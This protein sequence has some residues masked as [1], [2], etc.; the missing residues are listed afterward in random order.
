MS[1]GRMHADEPDIDTALV[2]RLI[3]GQF[4]GWKEL[5]VERVSSSGT[6][7]VMYRLGE[8]MVVRLPRRSAAVQDIH[9]EHVWLPRLAPRLPVPVPVPLAKG[10]PADGYPWPWSVYRWLEGHNPGREPLR[11]PAPLGEDLAGF[12]TA[13]RRIDPG[14][15]P[16]SYRDEPLRERDAVT[17]K[18]IGELSGVVDAAAATAEWEAALAAPAWDR[19]GVWIHADL[20]PGN[21]LLA[22]GRL[23]GVIDF[24]CLGLGDP[25]VDLIPAWYVLP[26]EARG[27]FRSALDCD[28]HAWARGRGWAL[29]VALLELSYYRESAP[30][31]AAIARRVIDEVLA[32]RPAA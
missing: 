24:G 20:Q 8:D 23:S 2:R 25:A 14:D 13:L 17:R 29:S 15:G 28:D 16:A 18:A 21:L 10:A 6:S 3:A 22:R 7:N 12:I 30:S 9:K 32:S 4:P 1:T 19:P 27:V 26:A 5:P 31:M 11:E